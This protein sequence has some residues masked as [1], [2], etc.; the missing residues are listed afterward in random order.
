MLVNDGFRIG[1]RVTYAMAINN[2]GMTG[3]G[4]GA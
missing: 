2:D 3:K 1:G 4:T